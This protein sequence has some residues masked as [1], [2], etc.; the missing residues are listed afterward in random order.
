[1]TSLSDYFNLDVFHLSSLVTGPSLMSIS[2]LVLESRQFSF[3]KN[4]AISVQY[5]LSNIWRL[6][7]VRDAK[8]CPNVSNKKLLNAAKC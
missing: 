5:V 6:A 3:I 4:W 7:Y 1:M 8:F 2:W